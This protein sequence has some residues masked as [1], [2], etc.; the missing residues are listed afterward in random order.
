MPDNRMLSDSDFPPLY[1]P[2]VNS[3]A[4]DTEALS[5]L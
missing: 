1:K 2:A 3:I 5:E 4:R